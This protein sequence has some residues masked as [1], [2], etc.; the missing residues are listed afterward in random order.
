MHH[1]GDHD[2]LVPLLDLVADELNVKAVAFAESA[3]QLGRW[4]AKPT[5]R[6]LGPRLG[7]KVKEVAAA[8]SR[9]DGSL[10]AALARGDSVTLDLG[11]DSI[12]LGPE[13]VD[14][15]QETQQGWG[16]E[17]EAGVTVALDLEPT[18]ELRAEGLARE[19]VRTV[20]DARKAAGLDVADRIALGLEATGE[21]AA[22][23]REHIDYIGGETLA[24]D[25]SPTPVGDALYGSESR[26]EG[27]PV[28]VTLA[29]RDRSRHHG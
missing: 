23:V 16:V 17:S 3:E 22:A 14:L 10:A 25:I 13:D 21:L 20:Q 28:M 29:R 11:T 12:T 9:D 8:L 18:P 24:V 6:V 15:T 19:V 26:I 1:A 5:F 2:A 4:R 7:P 27:M